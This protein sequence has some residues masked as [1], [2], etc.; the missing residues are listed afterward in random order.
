LRGFCAPAHF[1]DRRIVMAVEILSGLSIH[2]LSDIYSAEKKLIRSPP[3]RK[4]TL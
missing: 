2:G 4:S 1:V 3:L